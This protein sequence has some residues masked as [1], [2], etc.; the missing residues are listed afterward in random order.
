MVISWILV[1]QWAGHRIESSRHL[2]IIFAVYSL[3]GKRKTIG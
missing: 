3:Q 2:A 1:Y